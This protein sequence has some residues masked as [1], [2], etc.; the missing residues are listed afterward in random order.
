MNVH[1]VI[2][3]AKTLKKF[4]N[5]MAK[6]QY[7]IVLPKEIMFRVSNMSLYSY[8]TFQKVTS[9]GIEWSLIHLGKVFALM[10]V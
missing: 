4:T 6:L 9:M 5:F 3:V 8:L 1:L 2:M 10:L 7:P